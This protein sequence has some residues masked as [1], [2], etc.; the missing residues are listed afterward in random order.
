MG[1]NIF[2]QKPISP[3]NGLNMLMIHSTSNTTT[4]NK[5]TSKESIKTGSSM[6]D[7]FILTAHSAFFFKL[8]AECWQ[9]ITFFFKLIYY[10]TD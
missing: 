5:T 8:L 10:K 1:H 3:H 7:S 9:S 6:S 2:L 4:N